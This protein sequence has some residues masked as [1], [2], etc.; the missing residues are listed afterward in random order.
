MSNYQV[1]FDGTIAPGH[2]VD[3][4]KQQLLRLFEEDATFVERLFSGRPVTI[5]NNID[6]GAAQRLKNLMEYSG[7]ICRIELITEA[8]SSAGDSGPIPLA[9][10]TQSTLL[11]TPVKC[12]ALLQY[13]PLHCPEISAWDEGINLNRKDIQEIAFSALRMVSVFEDRTDS[14]RPFKFMFFVHELPRPLMV[15]GEKIRFNEFPGGSGTSLVDSLR[16]F[17]ELLVDSNPGLILDIETHRFLQKGRPQLVDKG[18]DVFAASLGKALETQV[19]VME[20]R[21]KES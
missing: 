4:V 2:S 7:A 6:E 17:L 15:N 14:A 12:R 16:I 18:I 11:I 5:Q 9:K 10:K 21:K 20:V 13:A 1:I 8:Q 19:S 3:Q